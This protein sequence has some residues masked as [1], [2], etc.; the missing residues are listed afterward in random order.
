MQSSNFYQST[1]GANDLNQGQQ[2]ELFAD[3]PFSLRLSVEEGMTIF[4]ENYW[5]KLPFG[6]ASRSHVKRILEFFK[7]RL[8]DTVSKHDVEAFREHLKGLRLSPSTINKH[9]MVLT[10]LF[11]KLMEYKQEGI[12]NGV[13]FS[14]ITLP[15]RNPAS[16]VP[17]VNESPFARKTVISPDDF[18]VLRSYADND[19]RDILNMLVWT[20]LRPGDLRRITVN[21]LNWYTNQME[22]IQHKTITTRNPSGVAYHA[23]ITPRIKE[24]LNYRISQVKPGTP[25]FNFTNIAKRWNRTR[26]MSGILLVQLRD[27]RRSG[28][29]YLMDNGTDEITVSEGLGHTTTRTT[30]VYVPR[31]KK[32]LAVATDKL[33]EAF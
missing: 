6:R 5:K 10:R 25:L 3:A 31:Q 24:L 29:T 30:R 33:V 21:N 17:K 19:L 27:L 16:M 32:H 9:Q 4:W 20:R 7:G 13:D 8:M 1:K 11:S 2:L 23:S 22:G 12:V 15:L 28:S 26:K 14:K 18:R